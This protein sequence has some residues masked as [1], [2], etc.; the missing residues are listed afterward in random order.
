MSC[1]AQALARVPST[2]QNPRE[3]TLPSAAKGRKRKLPKVLPE[4][5]HKNEKKVLM[6]GADH[7]SGW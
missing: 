6:F 1:P 2:G 7:F 3:Q 4:V 5:L